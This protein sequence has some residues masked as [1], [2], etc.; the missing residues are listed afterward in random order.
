MPQSESEEE[1]EV[2]DSGSE[3]E[4][5]TNQEYQNEYSEDDESVE[6]SPEREVFIKKSK[7]A[8]RNRRRR[9]R[10]KVTRDQ[11]KKH[12][13]ER[14]DANHPKM[15]LGKGATKNT[16]Q[17]PR[18]SSTEILSD[19]DARAKP[20]LVSPETRRERFHSILRERQESREEEDVQDTKVPK[21]K[22]KN[23]RQ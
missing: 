19:D 13:T 4:I 2:P 3:I 15:R 1:I 9:N 6:P 16:R 17:K 5:D 18:T 8:D 12:V 10:R 21:N 14:I 22:K 11:E 23:R 20:R 7:F